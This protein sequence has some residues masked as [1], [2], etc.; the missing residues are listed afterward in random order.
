MSSRDFSRHCM[1]VFQK[2]I[3]KG[4]D[5]NKPLFVWVYI[6]LVMGQGIM[7]ESRMKMTLHC[8]Q[9][10]HSLVGKTDMHPTDR[11]NKRKYKQFN[12]SYSDLSWLVGFCLLNHILIDR[13]HLHHCGSAYPPHK[14]QFLRATSQ[15]LASGVITSNTETSPSR[16]I[17]TSLRLMPALVQ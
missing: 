3:L 16:S 9:G 2:H 6:S 5:V 12:W 11:L 4:T 15:F 1:E 13:T 8:F 17:C 7:G 14:R 10:A